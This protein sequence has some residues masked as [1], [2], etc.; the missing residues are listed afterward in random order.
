MTDESK[1]DVVK[2][3][4]EEAHRIQWGKVMV[5]ATVTKGQITNV[6]FETRRS[7]NVNN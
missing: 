3:L 5:E 6:Q 1:K 4:E 7:K 2:I